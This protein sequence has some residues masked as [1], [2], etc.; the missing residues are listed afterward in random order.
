V[1]RYPRERFLVADKYNSLAG[2][3]YRKIFEEQLRRLHTD[4]IDFYLVHAVMDL[5][6]RGYVSNGC[7]EYFL[8]MKEEGK[9]G[10]LGFSTHASVEVTRDFADHHDWDFAQIQMNYYDWAFGHAKREYELLAKRGIPAVIMEPVRGGKLAKFQGASGATLQAAH[11]D[12]SAAS[13]AFRWLRQYDNA[14]VIL[15]GMSTMDQ[16]VDN[17]ATFGDRALTSVESQQLMESVGAHREAL[18]IPCTACR[19]C[20]DDCPQGIDIPVALDAYNQRAMGNVEQAKQLLDSLEAGPEDCIACSLCTS[21]CP[22][23]ID[24]PGAMVSL[25]ADR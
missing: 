15:S 13:W 16:I 8:K 11:P 23:G 4:H 2:G 1:K 21:H 17:V 20:T 12:W 25:A 5:N 22:Q 9:I 14:K 6:A 7:I 19:Y 18:A 24:I 3:N 10:H